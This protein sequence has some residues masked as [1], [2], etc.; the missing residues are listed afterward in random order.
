MQRT[1]RPKAFQQRNMLDRNDVEALFPEPPPG[2][3]EAGR[4]LELPIA[5]L[6]LDDQPRQIV[7]DNVLA[8]LIEEGRA[9]PALLL[10]ELRAVAKQHP[11]YQAVLQGILDLAKTVEADGVLEP[12]LVVQASGRYV[13]RDGHRRTLASLL[14]GRDTVPVRVMEEPSDVQAAARQ[15]IVNIQRADLTAIEKGRW[16]LRLARL[17]EQQARRDLGLDASSSV[18]DA[19]VSRSESDDEDAPRGASAQER[20]VA[21]VVRKRVCDL[22]GLSQRHYYN[23]IYLNR[24]SPEAREVGLGLTEGQLRPVTSLPPDEQAEIVS[25]IAAR[26]LTA[27]EANTLA[28]VARSGDRDAVRRLM[29]RLAREDQGRQRAQVSWEPLLHALPKDLWPRCAALRAELGALSDDLRQV[30]LR[31]MWEQRKLAEELQRQFDEI[32]AVYGYAGPGQANVAA[33]A[34]DGF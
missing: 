20:E 23:L 9:Q 32:F 6:W 29:S 15:L 28:Q 30:R 11:Y 16:L 19:L 34:V 12:L 33:P 27:K 2:P 5:D 24:L 7:P 8:G 14:A 21:A 3:A 26:S 31:S 13:V 22:T 18:V 1:A 10:E 25:F 4:L 17:V